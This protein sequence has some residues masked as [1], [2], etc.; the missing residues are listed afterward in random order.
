LKIF[1]DYLEISQSKVFDT[2]R[3]SWLRLEDIDNFPCED[4]RII[5]LLWVKYSHGHFGFSVQKEIYQGLG[6]TREYN[7]EVMEK[8]GED[9][10]WKKEGKWLYSSEVTCDLD[11]PKAHLPFWLMDW[12]GFGGW[13]GCILLS[14]RDL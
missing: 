1:S 12:L 2:K 4:L 9:V 5:D 6:G 11:K 10:G 13:G 14:R 7:R 3:Q 8:F